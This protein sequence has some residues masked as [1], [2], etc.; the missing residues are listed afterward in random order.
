M[1]EQDEAAV[2][3][4]LVAELMLEHP[5]L[6][7]EECLAAVSE[8]LGN[9]KVVT[10]STA[11]AA[12]PTVAAATVPPAAPAAIGVDVTGTEDD[13]EDAA[14][15]LLRQRYAQSQA[16]KEVERALAALDQVDSGAEADS[17]ATPA[18]AVPLT[19]R[20]DRPADEVDDSWLLPDVRQ[21]ARQALSAEQQAEIDQALYDAAREGFP[22]QCEHLIGKGAAFD[23][24]KSKN[25]A[26]AIH[27]ASANGH[28]A[29]VAV[30]L[31]VGGTKAKMSKNKVSSSRP[32]HRF[33]ILNA[34]R[35]CSSGNRQWTL[36]KST[37]ITTSPRYCTITW[38]YEVT[39]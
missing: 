20:G 16:K 23:G 9:R 36:P 10:S 39:V 38:P 14:L 15:S 12:V 30:L 26:T 31:E 25:N 18:P 6:T 1:A 19:P 27:A 2:V 8:S 34:R 32:Y 21:A 33:I 4:E 7:L 24:W 5:E 37:S 29:C 3:A 13:D 22:K 28:R 11:A 17:T 35:P